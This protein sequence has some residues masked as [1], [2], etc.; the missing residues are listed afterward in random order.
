MY[1][2]IPGVLKAALNLKDVDYSDIKNLSHGHADS[3]PSRPSQ[4][5]GKVKDDANKVTRRTRVSFE[6]HPVVMDGLEQEFHDMLVNI[7]ID[8][9]VSMLGISSSSKW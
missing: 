1:Y 4:S 2:S 7:D 8:D 5:Q 3:H 6:S 9:F